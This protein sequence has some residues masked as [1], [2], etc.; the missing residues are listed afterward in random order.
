M[1]PINRYLSPWIDGANA[2][3]FKGGTG[4]SRVEL[5]LLDP[6]RFFSFFFCLRFEGGTALVA[7]GVELLL[8]D[9]CR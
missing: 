6:C 1:M 4:L 8:L 5:L 9:P 3:V 2:G 7:S